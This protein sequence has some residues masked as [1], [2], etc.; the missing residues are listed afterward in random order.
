MTYKINLNEDDMKLLNITY[1]LKGMNHYIPMSGENR[2]R[3][4]EEISK[5]IY[6]LLEKKA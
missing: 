2:F 6:K 4:D 5:S 1:T 3:S